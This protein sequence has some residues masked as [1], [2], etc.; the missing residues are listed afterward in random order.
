M[1]WLPGHKNDSLAGR[2]EFAPSHGGIRL[3]LVGIFEGAELYGGTDP[4]IRI[5]GW[6][7]SDPVT[8]DRCFSTRIS[9]RSLGVTES[10]YYANQMLV[11]HH[12]EQGRL[13]FHQCTIRLGAMD[14]W[15]GRTGISRE[16]S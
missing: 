1:F 7:G 13:A 3:T 4:D 16:R 5:L 9:D 6:I 14:N 8:L 15:T 12:F 10:K 11:G 2:L